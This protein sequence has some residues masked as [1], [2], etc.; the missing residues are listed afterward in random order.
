MCV[1]VCACLPCISNKFPIKYYIIRYFVNFD[2]TQ[3]L[4]VGHSVSPN[5]C[6]LKPEVELSRITP[7]HSSNLANLG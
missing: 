6:G 4:Y 2:K 7:L 5:V 1:C 3:T